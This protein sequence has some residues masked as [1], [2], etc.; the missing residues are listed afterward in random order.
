MSDTKPEIMPIELYEE[1]YEKVY[2]NGG[3]ADHIFPSQA[4]LEESR[5]I[6][7]EDS[8]VKFRAS[9]AEMLAKL[10]IEDP[11]T[12]NKVTMAMSFQDR[13]GFES[14]VAWTHSNFAVKSKAQ[15]ERERSALYNMKT[16]GLY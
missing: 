16:A 3:P 6:D 4:W 11:R 15:A 8:Y 2:A 1:G 12:V 7:I 5:R 9:V 13:I 14:G 10:G